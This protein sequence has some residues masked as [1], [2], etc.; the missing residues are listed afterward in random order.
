MSFWTSQRS[1]YKVNLQVFLRLWVATVRD[2]VRKKHDKAELRWTGRNPSPCS[3][4][5][6]SVIF[7]YYLFDLF[8]KVLLLLLLGML[9]VRLCWLFIYL[10]IAWERFGWSIFWILHHIIS[11][12]GFKGQ[13][14]TPH[15]LSS[16]VSKGLR[17]EFSLQ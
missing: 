15:L 14:P 10:E 16:L 5:H 8:M 17:D 9:G 13:S 6:H 12:M 4:V 3:W 7:I 2:C 11:T 1:Q